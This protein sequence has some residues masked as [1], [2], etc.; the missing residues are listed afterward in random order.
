MSDAEREYI[1]KACAALVVGGSQSFFTNI[2]ELAFP[3]VAPYEK[4][5]EGSKHYIPGRSTYDIF[6]ACINYGKSVY[7]VEEHDGSYNVYRIK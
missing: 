1:G 6:R 3:P 2:V 7:T 4:M 5:S